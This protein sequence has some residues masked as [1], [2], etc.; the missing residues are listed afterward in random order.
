MHM[1]VQSLH[2]A[3]T[4]LYYFLASLPQPLSIPPTPLAAL[5][6]T[7]RA[8]APC[9]A[10]LVVLAYPPRLPAESRFVD[11]LRAHFEVSLGQL[12]V[13]GGGMV[14]AELR[15]KLPQVG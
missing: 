9:R 13:Q 14:V 2:Y 15:P 3:I 10:T 12:E 8:L 5:L 6:R 7:L 1:Q 11:D 4:L